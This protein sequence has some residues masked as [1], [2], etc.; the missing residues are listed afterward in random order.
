MS[1]TCEL[2][3]ESSRELKSLFAE[4]ELVKLR[5]VSGHT[6]GQSAANRSEASIFIDMLGKSAGHRVV[7]LQG[8]SADVRNGRTVTRTWHWP[9][10]LQVD[11]ASV[12]RG[13]RDLLAMVDVDYYVDMPSMLANHIYHRLLHDNQPHSCG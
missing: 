13:S 12:K 10:D 8:S 3:T 6:H 5:P 4:A 2:Y 1:K 9:K 7:Q 11:P